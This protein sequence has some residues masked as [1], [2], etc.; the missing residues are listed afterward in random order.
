MDSNR[1]RCLVF[2]VEDELHLDAG[3]GHDELDT[4]SARERKGL[5][6]VRVDVAVEHARIGVVFIE[7]TAARRRRRQSRRRG[8]RPTTGRSDAT[9][10]PAALTHTP[11]STSPGHRPHP[12]PD[13]GSG[14]SVTGHCSPRATDPDASAHGVRYGTR[15]SSETSVRA[16]SNATTPRSSTMIR[17]EMRST[18]PRFCSTINK[19]TREHEADLHP[20]PVRTRG[21]RG[22]GSA[23]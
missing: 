6:N 8:R 13:G 4:M 10:P 21:A 12:H 20:M 19:A 5:G 16:R 17:S 15:V 2:D 23:R 11:A 18:K 3:V 1:R 14:L 22:T 9:D 7:S